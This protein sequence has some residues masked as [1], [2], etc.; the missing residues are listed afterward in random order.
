M[1]QAQTQPD[2]AKAQIEQQ[3]DAAVD[4]LKGAIAR[5]K[6]HDASR[7]PTTPSEATPE[8]RRRAFEAMRRRAPAP[9]MDARARSALEAGRA[10]VAR[11]R[12]A[13]A[14]RLGQALG[15]EAPDT[16]AL[17][18]TIAP[19]AK[20]GWVPVLFVS[21]SIPVSTL[22][23]Y[24]GQLEKA[25]GVIAFRGMPGGLNKV[26]P[27]A[28]LSAE[29]LRIDPGCE[30]PACAMRDI[31]LIVDPII[32]RQHGITRVPA[33][34]MIPGDPT[35]PYCE[36]EDNSPRSSHIVQGDAALPGLL[37][38]Y[39]RLGGREEVRDAQARLESR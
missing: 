16:T 13:M 25:R 35:Q 38:E 30:G 1:V 7:T 6:P 27:M 19:P 2:G 15:L 32:F 4:R 36:R 24:V 39:G 34:A 12:E 22:R 37:E 26:A 29:I 8:T 10:D 28:K 14:K 31:Q 21:S 5:Q 17:A 18:K 20:A 11:E 23:T 33:L 3:G 9:A